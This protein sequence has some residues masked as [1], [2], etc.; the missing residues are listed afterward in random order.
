MQFGLFPRRDG[1]SQSSQ[2]PLL[3]PLPPTCQS[4][5][6]IPSLLF[7]GISIETNPSKQIGSYVFASRIEFVKV[8][9]ESLLKERGRKFND[10]SENHFQENRLKNLLIKINKGFTGSTPNQHHKKFLE[11]G[12]RDPTF[13]KFPRCLH[14]ILRDEGHYLT[15]IY[16]G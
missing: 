4:N 7:L 3:Q 1:N 2:E 14:C 15:Q 9:E 5:T 8:W 6:L 11:W 10:L 12:L 16:V 13:I